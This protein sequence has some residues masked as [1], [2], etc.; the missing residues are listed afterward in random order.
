MCLPLDTPRKSK[1]HL[2]FRIP[3]LVS[4]RFHTL[5]ELDGFQSHLLIFELHIIY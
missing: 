5:L 4:V 2:S 3:L 1:F